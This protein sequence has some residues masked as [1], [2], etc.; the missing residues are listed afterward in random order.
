[1]AKLG[2]CQLC[3]HI[4]KHNTG[5]KVELGGIKIDDGTVLI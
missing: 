1:M 4:F 3:W 5:W 2:L